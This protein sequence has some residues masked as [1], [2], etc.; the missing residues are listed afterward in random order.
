LDRKIEKNQEHT[1]KYLQKKFDSL[2]EK[3]FTVPKLVGEGEKFEYLGEYLEEQYYDNRKNFIDVNEATT[4][5]QTQLDKLQEFVFYQ[6]NQSVPEKLKST[7]HDLS[8]KI[9]KT[10]E[11][12]HFQIGRQIQHIEDVKLPEHRVHI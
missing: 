2:Q 10:I 1:A 12:T 8:N 7:E 6:L 5:A 4:K 9:D 11:E 3:Q